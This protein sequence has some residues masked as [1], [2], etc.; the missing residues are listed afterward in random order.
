M[1]TPS[2]ATPPAIAIAGMHKWYGEF[3]VLQDINLQ[4]RAGERLVIC[5]PSG[6]G[7]STMI[8]CINRLER[9]QQ[10]S[11]VVNGVE[12]TDDLRAVDGVRTDAGM[13]FQ[14]FNLFPHLTVLENCILAPTQVRRMARAQA[15]D[16]A[17]RYLERVRIPDQAGKYPGQLSGG[18]QQRVAIARS[19]C[20]QPRIMLFDEPTSALDPEM[21]KEVLDTMTSLAEDGMTM[22]CV[23]HEMGFARNVADRVVFMD[24]G[25][26]IE[27]G[28]P[29]DFFDNPR[30]ERTRAFL[31]RILH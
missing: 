27:M 18:Q 22:L 24:G 4:V 7:K 3:H 8:R 21:V 11:I 17:M 20:M 2:A 1:T 9:H 31:E 14:H 30:H 16:L 28:E 5:G 19:L 25:R 13:V 12:L 26:I 6:S 29:G 10:G 23:T 15:V